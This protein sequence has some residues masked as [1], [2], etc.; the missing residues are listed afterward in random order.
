LELLSESGKVS[1][2]E[3]FQDTIEKIILKIGKL[4]KDGELKY[5]KSKSRKI[6]WYDF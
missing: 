3:K 2:L 6:E 1:N 5:G 4:N